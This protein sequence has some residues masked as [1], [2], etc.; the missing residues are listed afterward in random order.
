MT[1][2]G[3]DFGL[4]SLIQGDQAE[5]KGEVELELTLVKLIHRALVPGVPIRNIRRRRGGG[6][7]GSAERASWW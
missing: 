5:V 4:E 6:R 3:D 2:H 1:Y 7:R